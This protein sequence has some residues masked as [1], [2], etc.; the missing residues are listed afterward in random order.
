[1]RRRDEEEMSMY[2]RRTSEAEAEEGERETSP[3][4]HRRLRRSAISPRR[5]KRRAIKGPDCW[6]LDLGRHK[7]TE[8]AVSQG[9]RGESHK[10]HKKKTGKGRR[11]KRRK[12][13]ASQARNDRPSSP[14]HHQLSTRKSVTRKREGVSVRKGA[15]FHF[16]NFH[17]PPQIER[18]L[19]F[20]ARVEACARHRPMDS[21]L[22]YPQRHKIRKLSCTD[23][24]FCV[25]SATGYIRV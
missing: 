13:A 25:P 3:C 16:P 12:R 23:R 9:R 8:E 5:R 18:R 15:L 20:P 1:M 7:R 10:S 21:S 17:S 14:A 11:R 19:H 22:T 4:C 24:S 2:W 6:A